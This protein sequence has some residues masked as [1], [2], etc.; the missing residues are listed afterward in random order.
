M[1]DVE[2]V[3]K[4]KTD[5]HRGEHKEEIRYIIKRI[6]KKHGGHH[7]GAWKIAYADFVTAMMAFFL[8]MW[9]LSMLNK[10]QLEGISEYFRHPLAD[11]FTKQDASSHRD[12][13]KDFKHMEEQ[14]SMD[15]LE[16]MKQN[17]M[18]DLQ[19]NK[20]M[21]EFKNQ[22]NF[23]VTNDGLKIQLRDLEK[24]AMFTQGKA[25]FAQHAKKLLTWL[26]GEINQ[27]PNRLIILGHTDSLPYQESR[28]YGNW[29]LSADRA[30]ATRRALISAGMSDQKIL[31]VIGAA[32]TTLLDRSNAFDARNR[33]IEIVVLTD[34]ASKKL[35]SDY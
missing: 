21:S 13:I 9:L 11:A 28:N 33:R 27:Y 22:L 4:E 1:A 8:L 26:S 10:Y 7:G 17:I 2:E 19:K 16:K 32:D 15:D 31:R 25:D 5:T 24:R 3:E 35:L 18:N 6:K 23:E 12:K 14:K 34:K 29:E 30:N 20:E